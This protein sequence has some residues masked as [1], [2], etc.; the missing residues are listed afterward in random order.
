MNLPAIILAIVLSFLPVFFWSAILKRKH[1]KGMTFFFALNFILSAGFAA[2]FHHKLEAIIENGI[3]GE[4]DHGALV[5]V[6]Y[7]IMGMLIE[8]GK[9]FIV[10]MTGGKYFQTIDDVMDLSFAT[11]L[12]FTFYRNIFHFHLLFIGANPDITGPI[13]ILKDILENVFFILPI[14]LFCSGIFGYF[15]GV[16]IFA[17]EK[18]K[19]A[20][21]DRLTRYKIF[22]FRTMKVMEG[23]IISVFFYGLFFTILKMDPT[24]GDIFSLVGLKRVV[25]F[26]TEIDERVMPIISFLFF[27]VGTIFLFQL[28]DQKREFSQKAL[29]F[30]RSPKK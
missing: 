18:L 11:A 1:R 28:M 14:H 12:W 5:F 29:L 21:K 26:G 20:H 24:I 15:Y 19:E 22:A 27:G 4:N 8:Y 30:D 3:L 13:K 2:L 25:L 16:S 17:T 6:S 7:M 10:R 23:T 9:N